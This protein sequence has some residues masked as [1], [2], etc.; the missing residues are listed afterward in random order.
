MLIPY[1]TDAP[2]YHYPI[3]TGSLI[4]V[5]VLAFVG[6]VRHPEVAEPWVLEFGKMNPLQWFTAMFL[7]GNL[8]HLLGNLV[9][10]LI[11]GLIVEGK[12]GWWKMLLVYLGI[13]AVQAACVQTLMLGAEKGG[14]LG[15]SGAIY[16]LL[17]ISMIWAPLNDIT[18][19]WIVWFR[20]HTF[21][22]KVWAIAF[23]YLALQFMVAVITNFT[24]SS[25]VLHLLGAAVGAVVGVAMV[26]QQWVDCENWDV[27]SVNK[28]RHRMTREQLAEEKAQRPE[29]VE[30]LK[31]RR[32]ESLKQIHALIAEGNPALAY[33]AHDHCRRMFPD[34]TFSDQDLLR[35]I[36]KY[37]EKGQWRE[38]IPAMAEYIRR[39]GAPQIPV[40]RLRL[41][42]VLLEQDERPA[43]ALRVLAKIPQGALNESQQALRRQL[44]Q[45]AAKA[46][47]SDPYEVTLE[48]W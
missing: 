28:G 39:P 27:F 33:A 31:N 44:E 48:D 41:A 10:L 14:A 12:I 42:R 3:T 21:D 8:L 32:E 13:G 15:A 22:V 43:Q 5:N 16:G 9:F 7:H 46:H 45:K 23:M 24:M 19:A 4:V 35:I 36:A 47:E 37:H 1:S 40:V 11:F 26:K 2:L 6:S 34:W 18:C 25:E 20:V 17:A 29:N 38:S 30:K